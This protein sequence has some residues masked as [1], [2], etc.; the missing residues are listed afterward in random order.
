MPLERLPAGTGVRRRPDR[1]TLLLATLAVV[2]AV[3]VMAR[4]VNYGVVLVADAPVYLSVADSLRAGTG[5]AAF[6]DWNY[7]LWPPLYPMLLA[8]ASLYVF[9]PH[10]V[11]GPLNAG[12]LGLTIFAVGHCL[13][14]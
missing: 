10:D 1:L 13:R 8:A 12:I 14:R 5:F 2:G 9:D 7:S 4:Q 3:L 6:S 11:A